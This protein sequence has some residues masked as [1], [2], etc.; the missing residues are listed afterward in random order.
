MDRDMP[1]LIWPSKNCTNL[2]SR[3]SICQF[4]I[5]IQ[6]LYWCQQSWIVCC[7]GSKPD[8]HEQ[9]IAYASRALHPTEQNN[10]NYSSLKLELLGLKCK[11]YLTGAKFIV[12]TDNNSVTHL[13]TA[14]L[15][16]TEQRWVAQ[17]AF[18]DWWN[19]VQVK[20]TQMQMLCRDFL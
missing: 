20:R 3:I 17:L 11:D 9:V 15:G 5:A 6:C 13:Q 4:H 8:G 16:T 12:Y 14:K 18:F 19:I 1:I 2:V 7:D 10:A